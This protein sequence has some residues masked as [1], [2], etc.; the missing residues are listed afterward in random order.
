VKELSETNKRLL[1]EDLRELR[2]NILRDRRWTIKMGDETIGLIDKM[3][4]S[5]SKQLANMIAKRMEW[6]GFCQDI[7]ESLQ[8]LMEYNF[9]DLE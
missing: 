8:S 6:L 5:P 2:R 9:D 3:L 1:K 7:G 4:A